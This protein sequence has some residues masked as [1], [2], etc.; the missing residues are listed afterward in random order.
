MP[1]G[2]LYLG[3]T[4]VH[5]SR[6]D[7]RLSP[8]ELTLVAAAKGLDF[9]ALADHAKGRRGG[10]PP[11]G[12]DGEGGG[13]TVLP[14]QEISA[15]NHLHFVVMGQVGP[16][17]EIP[18]A[19]LPELAAEAHAAGGVVVLA[20]PWTLFIR[21][22]ERVR[23]VDRLFAEGCLDGVEVISGALK[24]TEFG[25]WQRTF[26]HY[27]REWA[28]YGP[29]A[30]AGS[31]WHHRSHGRALALSATY[32]AAE[33]LAGPDLLRGIA[34]RRTA[35]FLPPAT[36]LEDGMYR[37]Y[38]RLVDAAE[39]SLPGV[40]CCWWGD[41]FGPPGMLAQIAAARHTVEQLLA[42]SDW[43]LP[44]GRARELR[45]AA[46]AAQAAGNYRRALALLSPRRG[47]QS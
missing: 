15:G 5:S 18:L 2:Q 43:R 32:V 31:D 17:H 13:V 16:L 12:N 6:S 30:L 39:Q 27:L 24:P 29:A 3:D 46:R 44:G 23:Q 10:P 28:P 35:V 37:E 34:A 42:G 11:S 8:S 21:T 7:G 20:H 9:F 47:E 40:G 41:L 36:G 4:H 25:D 1:E 38:R 14:G 19:S 26:L 22:P 45:Q 33:S